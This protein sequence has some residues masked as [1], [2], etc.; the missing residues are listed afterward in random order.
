MENLKHTKLACVLL[1]CLLAVSNGA[2]MSAFAAEDAAP[3]TEAAALNAAP[4]AADMPDATEEPAAEDATETTEEA[5]TETEEG[6][7]P[8]ENETVAEETTESAEDE[9][10]AVTFSKDYPLVQAAEGEILS[11]T[12]SLATDPDAEKSGMI[13]DANGAS[14]LSKG[15]K[16][17]GHFSVTPDYLKGDL[18]G[19][20]SVDA[21]DA[22]C[23]LIAA[24]AAGVG[25]ATAGELIAEKFESV[26][27]DF[28]AEQI[29]DINNDGSINASDAAEV[30][31]YASRCGAGEA[32]KPLGCAQYYA[33]ENGVLQTGWINDNTD[34]LHANEDYTLSEGWTTLEGTTYYFSEDAKMQTG[35]VKLADQTYYLGQDGAMTTGWLDTNDG[36][37]YFDVTTGKQAFGVQVIDGSFYYFDEKGA[38]GSGG[39]LNCPDGRRY[40]DKIGVL[41]TEWQEIDGNTYYFGSTGLLATGENVIGGKTYIFD[42]N[43]IQKN[44]VPQSG[45]RNT[46]QGKRYYLDNGEMAVGLLKMDDGLRFFDSNGVMVTGDVPLRDIMATSKIGMDELTEKMYTMI[47]SHNIE[48][49]YVTP[50]VERV[51]LLP[52]VCYHFNEDGVFAPTT[53][54][55]VDAGH[56][57]KYNHSPVVN[58]YWESD[59]TWRIHL[60]L[61]KALEAK[62]I[63]VVTTRADKEKD[64][65]LEE[66]GM[67]SKGCDLFISLHSNACSNSST[68]APLACCAING[69]TDDLGQR[70][71][72]LVARVMETNQGGEIWKRHGIKEP[73][74]DY[75]SVIRGANN[76]GT[77][78]VLL[79][80]S[81]HTNYRATMWLLN[82]DNC[83]RMA[84]AEADFLADYMVEKA[85]ADLLTLYNGGTNTRVEDAL[86]WQLSKI[87]DKNAPDTESDPMIIQ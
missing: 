31:I 10:E 19:D 80:H 22:A 25:D 61:V 44:D 41:A 5:T 50:I 26:A 84:D 6:T 9:T 7:A 72:D 45:W 11:V 27:N 55:C 75:Y 30:L 58:E 81:Y 29:A 86:F 37:Y 16:L 53:T 68:D 85:E 17:T 59:F 49:K 14:Y 1:S 48:K 77:P 8:A 43:G 62:G 64:L 74:F 46:E 39:W 56:Y 76:V 23:I 69:S 63:N 52:D 38:L 87:V 47:A 18:G 2:V 20:G 40:A 35:Y 54:I 42:E 60:H 82:D 32:V 21:S 3:D 65:G 83:K 15:K 73:Q 57:A 70:L 24:S 28:Q 36:I 12:L 67:V 33:D 66:R 71:A 13:H 34:K 4:A 79:E 51:E 78:G